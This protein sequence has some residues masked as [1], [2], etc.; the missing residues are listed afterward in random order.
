MYRT[1]VRPSKKD[2]E[3]NLKKFVDKHKDS[4]STENEVQ[5]WLEQ[6]CSHAKREEV[7][8]WRGGITI[9]HGNVLRDGTIMK[10]KI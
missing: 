10:R 3:G 4:R 7:T 9:K 8:T 1:G 5:M 6:N 2:E